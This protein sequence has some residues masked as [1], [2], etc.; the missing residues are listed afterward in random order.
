MDMQATP[1]PLTDP[2]AVRTALLDAAMVHVAFD[3]W[4]EATFAAA[5]RDAGIP[6]EVA[7]TACPRGALDLAVAFHRQGDTAMT[8][9]LQA[10]DL[11]ALRIR[12]KVTLAVRTRIEAAADREAVR[13]GTTLFALPQ[14][15]AEGAGLIWGTADAIWTALGDPSDDVNWYT[16][17]ATL[18]GVY[19]STVLY[20]LGDTSEGS[21]ATWA[22]LDRRIAD[23]MWI[24]KVK[25]QLNGNPLL[26][27]LM[28][29]PNWLASRIKAPARGTQAE[30]P[31]YWRGS[32]G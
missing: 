14:H 15:A 12:E 4:T 10:T 29:G 16:K 27:P 13:R 19:G 23:V 22:F 32:A 26:K 20:W 21:E 17:R 1:D 5:A 11:A 2:H 6:A 30:M 9:T 31:G 25:A 8:E 18:S 7:R 28:A 24:E 3:G